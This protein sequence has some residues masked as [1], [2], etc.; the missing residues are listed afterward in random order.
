MDN[1]ETRGTP[2]PRKQ[3]KKKSAARRIV[4]IT[5]LLLFLY[6]VYFVVGMCVPF[7]PLESTAPGTR[8]PASY[9][10]D[11]TP[12]VERASVIEENSD[13]LDW[14]LRLIDAATVSVSFATYQ[15]RE[16]ESTTLLAEALKRAAERGVK[17]RILVDGFNDVLRM[18]GKTYEVADGDII[19][20][21]FTS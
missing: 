20:F 11:G 5:L 18:E 16:G 12:W 19:T 7:L 17:V 10:G 2:V 13:A 3:K 14:R 8:D 9:R 15:F 4:G 21:H 1:S 6:L